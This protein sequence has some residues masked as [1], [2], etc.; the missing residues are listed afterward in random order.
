RG[1]CGWSVGRA[2]WNALVGGKPPL[3]LI[4]RSGIIPI[5][6]SQDTAGPLGRTVADATALLGAMTGVDPA[7]RATRASRRYARRDYTEFLSA[8]GL[9]RLRVGVPRAVFFERLGP[10]EAPVIDSAVRA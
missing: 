10:A 6:A 5:A 2:R 8:D 7:D 3:G 1:T 9:E 4:S